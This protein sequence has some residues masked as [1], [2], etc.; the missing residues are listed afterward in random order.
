MYVYESLKLTDKCEILIRMQMI[1]HRKII[2]SFT[3]GSQFVRTYVR[4]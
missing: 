2:T 4:I 3:T 1:V